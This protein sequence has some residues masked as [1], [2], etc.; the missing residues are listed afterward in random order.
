AARS[1]RSGPTSGPMGGPMS[2]PNS[3]AE[4]ATSRFCGSCGARISGNETFCGQCGAPVN[5]GSQPGSGTGRYALGGVSSWD[6]NDAYTE[7]MPESPTIAASHN[8]FAVDSYG[9]SYPQPY[10]QHGGQAGGM[11]RSTRLTWGIVCLAISIVL[12]LGAIA[13]LVL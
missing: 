3:G 6:D 7:A 2:G 9:R 5:V 1:P 4:R 12:A 11:T 10:G 13:I 8:P